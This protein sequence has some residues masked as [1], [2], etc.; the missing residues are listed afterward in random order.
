MAKWKHVLRWTP[1]IFGTKVR[2]TACGTASALSRMYVS[3][4]TL[5]YDALTPF[6]RGGMIAPLLGGALL[7]VDQ[8]FPVYTSVVVYLVT[9]VFVLLLQETAGHGGERSFV[10]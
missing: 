10:H 8:A 9:G 6:D 2:G 3:S 7:V 5:D 4:P 1:E